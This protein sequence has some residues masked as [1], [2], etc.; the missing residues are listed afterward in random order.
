MLR[1]QSILNTDCDAGSGK[2]V[3]QDPTRRFYPTRVIKTSD[4][5]M[6]VVGQ[7]IVYPNYLIS[8]GLIMKTDQEGNPAWINMVG[9]ADN[10]SYHYI[11]YWD[12]VEITDGFIAF[13]TTEN[14]S[15]YN[16][17]LILT[18]IS[19]AGTVI[20]HRIFKSKY[21]TNDHGS[22]D[23]FGAPKLIYDA[24][25]NSVYL[26]AMNWEKGRNITKFST[27][28]GDIAWSRAYSM[29]DV[30]FD[31]NMGI[32]FGDTE[33]YS[34]GFMLGDY[35]KQLAAYRINKA[36]GN[37]IASK[38]YEVDAPVRERIVIWGQHSASR[39]A[40][41]NFLVGGTNADYAGT[42]TNDYYRAGLF[43]FDAT[44]NLVKGT[45]I[46]SAVGGNANN[47]NGFE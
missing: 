29:W 33:L 38:F 36:N 28:N 25:E 35:V 37:L 2:S 30:G 4:N 24:S 39:L 21:W 11:N 32:V 18:K 15:N 1:T 6:L 34:F 10:P 26:S 42:N 16:H 8:R 43:E 46:R 22:P 13:G 27:G 31:Y 17:D 7:T 44:L 23:Y 40:N 3:F 45:A 14:H 5:Q 41:G 12:V 19:P 47:I 20:W 9:R